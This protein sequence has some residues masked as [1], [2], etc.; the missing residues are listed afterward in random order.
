MYRQGGPAAGRGPAS[1][2]RLLVDIGG[3]VLV[4]VGRNRSAAMLSQRLSRQYNPGQSVTARVTRIEPR[5]VSSTY[6]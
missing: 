2:E 4:E 5:R 6:P 3:G 1:A